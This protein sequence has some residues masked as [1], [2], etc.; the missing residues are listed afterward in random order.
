MESILVWRDP[1]IRGGNS[2]SVNSADKGVGME[3][4]KASHVFE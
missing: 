1:W 3:N 2:F 4:V